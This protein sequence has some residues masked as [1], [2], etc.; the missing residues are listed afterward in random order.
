MPVYPVCSECKKTLRGKNKLA[1]TCSSRCRSERV[2]RKK[3]QAAAIAERGTH[4]EHVSRAKMKD[5]AHE[6]LKEELRPAIA[7]SL[8]PDVLHGLGELVA[9]VPDAVAR[10]REDLDSRDETIRQRAYFHVMKYTL[11]NPAVAPGAPEQTPQ[12][13]QVSFVMPRPGVATPELEAV[14]EELATCEACHIEQP[15]SAFVANSQRCQ[16]CH[17]AIQA[18]VAN[19]FPSA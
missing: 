9:M 13:M 17:D 16:T 5:A 15:R 3:R 6:V 4:P 10:L 7:A 18:R 14:A 11:G 19:R 1:R 2:R 12:P 8:T